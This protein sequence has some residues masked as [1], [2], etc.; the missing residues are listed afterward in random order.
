MNSK[1]HTTDI[2]LLLAAEELNLILIY[3][4]HV[5][6]LCGRSKES[7]QHVLNSVDCVINHQIKER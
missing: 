6:E 4:K 3:L 1:C 7:V 2:L 5:K